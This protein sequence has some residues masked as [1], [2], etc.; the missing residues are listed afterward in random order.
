LSDACQLG[1]HTKLPFPTSHSHA[2][3][4]FDLIH[5][6]LWTF[7]VISCS[8][9]KFYLVIVDYFSHF[10][11]VFPLRAKSDTCDTLLRFFSFVTTQFNTTIR[12]H[13]VTMAE[14]F[15][16]PYFVPI[17]LPMMSSVHFFFK[18]SYPILLGRSPP[19]S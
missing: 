12:C 8:G 9:Y 5:C 16:P 2:L 7:P 6:D 10:T 15:S 13:N 18:P 1:K 11:W 4:P 3:S 19:H 14:N 17:S